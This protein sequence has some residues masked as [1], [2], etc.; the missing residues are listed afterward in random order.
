MNNKINA[1]IFDWAG[2]TIDQGSCGPIAAFIEIFAAKGIKIKGDQVRGPMGMHKIAHIKMLS[3]LPEINEQWIKNYGRPLEDKDI[4]DLFTMFEPA[5][6][7]SLLNHAKLIPGV[8]DA[9]NILKAKQIKIGSTT[10]YSRSQMSIIIPEAKKQ[11]FCP[12][13]IVCSSDVPEGRPSP[14]ML[15][16]AAKQLKAY[17]PSTWVKVDDTLVGIQEGK[18]AGAWTIGV[19]KTGNLVGL[20]ENELKEIPSEE[21]KKRISKAENIFQSNGVDFVIETVA[22][23]TYVL[24]EIEQRIKTG[25]KPKS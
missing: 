6:E 22:E 17:P 2:T 21:L 5:L 19:T 25:I 15:F 10:G 11:G 1:I 23:I 12:D 20:S 8:A 4:H 9:V 18:N 24:A 14:W 3:E 13:S 7:K 16:E